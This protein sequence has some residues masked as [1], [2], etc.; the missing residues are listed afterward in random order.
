MKIR[1]VGTPAEIAAALQALTESRLVDITAVSRTYPAG[2]DTA[3]TRL[4]LDV[5]PA[6]P[7]GPAEEEP[8]P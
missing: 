7:T 4:Y 5:R 3:R 8:R 1:L 6:P 2:H